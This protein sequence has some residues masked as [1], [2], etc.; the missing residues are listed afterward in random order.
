AKINAAIS[1]SGTPLAV[2]TI[3]V[4]G[5][6]IRL[7]GTTFT[8]MP[9]EPPINIG[10]IT[11]DGV[12]ASGNGYFIETVSFPNIDAVEDKTHVSIADIVMSNVSV[13]ADTTGDTL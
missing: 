6:T 12:E 10:E 3:D 7:R 8:P 9:G 11:L 1:P 2:Q 5:S 13:P 4:R